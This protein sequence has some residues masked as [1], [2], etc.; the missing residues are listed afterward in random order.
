MMNLARRFVTLCGDDC[1]L[2][3]VSVAMSDK[4]ALSDMIRKALERNGK[5]R[6]IRPSGPL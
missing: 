5:S 6:E 1:A 3:V 2:L 4:I